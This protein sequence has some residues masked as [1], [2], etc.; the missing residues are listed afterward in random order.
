MIKEFV[1]TIALGALLGFGITGGFFAIK[2]NASKSTTSQPTPAIVNDTTPAPSGTDVTSQSD[3]TT[4][5][6]S[7]TIESPDNNFL[8]ASSKLTVKGSTSP[9]S[10]VII[11]TPSSIFTGKADTA[12]NFSIDID[13][14]SGANLV[15]VESID[16]NDNQTKAELLVTY[17]TAKI[18]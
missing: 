16:P 7:L 6:H 2:K 15:S 18:E 1:V 9:D 8:T 4:Q 12:G 17:S 5:S 13:L 3:L 11:T 14:D 10:N